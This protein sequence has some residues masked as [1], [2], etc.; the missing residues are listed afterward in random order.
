MTVMFILVLAFFYIFN[1]S[2]VNVFIVICE[3][4]LL[5]QY[6][7]CSWKKKNSFLSRIE[8]A[9]SGRAAWIDDVRGPFL[10]LSQIVGTGNKIAPRLQSTSR[11]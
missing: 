9:V 3:T 7:Y 10:D 5:L 8:S 6:S 11:S 2:V 1:M 4:L